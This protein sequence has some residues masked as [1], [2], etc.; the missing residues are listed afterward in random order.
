MIPYPNISPIALSLGPVK[1]HWYGIMYLTTFLIAYYLIPIFFKEKKIPINKDTV[2][3]LLLTSLIGVVFGGRLGYILFYQLPFYLGHPLDMFKIWEGGMSFHGGMLGVILGF[4]LFARKNK[5]KL[6]QLTDAIIPIIP[7]GIFLVR[8]GNFINAELYGRITNS[9]ICMRFPTDPLNCRYPSQLIEAL[10]EGAI[11][12]IILFF[13][14]TAQQSCP[15]G[16]AQQ[17]C[18]LGEKIKTPGVLSWLFIGLYGLFRFFAEFFREPDVQIGYLWNT[19][20]LGQTFSILMITTGII[21]ICFAK[22]RR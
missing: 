9:T 19:I 15:L 3:D 6:Y 17:S 5:I 10:L 13:A 2:S 8:I 20:T 14:R 1:I 7:I 21:G 4:I 16:T 11:L 22:R 18:P 12:F